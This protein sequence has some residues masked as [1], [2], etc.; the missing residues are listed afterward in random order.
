MNAQGW[1][2]KDRIGREAVGGAPAA[3]SVS[4]SAPRPALLARLLDDEKLLA[5]L[6]L[7]PTVLLLAAFIAYPFAMGIWLAMSNASVGNPGHFIGIKNFTKAWN[8]S[9]FRTTFRFAK[10]VT[11]LNR[12]LEVQSNR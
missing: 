7:S 6:L 11:W 12:G 5:L 2:V 4:P 10:S 9:I 3:A 1:D 8:D